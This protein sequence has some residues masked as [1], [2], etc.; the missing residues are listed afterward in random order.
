MLLLVSQLQRNG[1]THKN[2]EHNVLISDIL[3]EQDQE[4]TQAQLDALEKVLDRVFAQV[5]IDVE[6][7]RHFLDRVN[8][9]R[10]RRQI[11]IKEL[12]LLFKKEFIKHGKPIARM[13]PDAEAVMKDMETDINLPFALRWDA[14]NNELDLIA[15]TVMRKSDFRTSNKTFTVERADEVYDILDNVE[16]GPFDGGCVLVAQALQQIH[17]GDIVVLV[18][19]QGI[20][21]HAAVKVGNNLIDFDGALP[22]KQ[23]IKRFE[24]NERVDIK[25]IRPIQKGDLPEAPRD[26]KLVPQLVN[27]LT[28]STLSE[29][30]KLQLERGADMDVLHITDTATG[31]RTE[32]RGKPNYETNYDA[33]DK[34]HQLLDRIGKASNISDLINGEV[35]GINPRHPDGARA[36][37]HAD[38]AFNENFADGKVKGKSRPGRVKKAGASCKGSVTDLRAK[39]KKY[40]GERGKMYHWCANMKAGKKK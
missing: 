39:A 4:V 27:A 17:G 19:N 5:G 21:D 22:V 34:L 11:T 1:L 24:D 7:T 33:D 37:K 31:R 36:K 26:E 6:F 23:F 10:N 14:N 30:Y 18:N 25:G 28:E 9:E 15:K 13:G 35:V 32:V 16:C 29:G 38:T 20:A 8:D 3:Y 40:S 12:G 2:Q